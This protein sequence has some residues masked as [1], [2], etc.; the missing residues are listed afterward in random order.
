MDFSIASMVMAFTAGIL[1]VASPCVFPLLP[2]IASGTSNDHKLRPLMITAGLT[3]TFILMG[4]VSSVFGSLIASKMFY[5]EKGAGVI[6]VV[7]GLLMIFDINVF[8]KLTLFNNIKTGRTG[9][10]SGFFLGLTLGLIWIPCV[11][12]VLTSVLALVASEGSIVKGI[13]LLSIYSAGFSIPIL[14]AGYFSQFFRNRLKK[15]GTQSFAIRLIGG[16]VLVIF[17]IYIFTKGL[18]S[19]GL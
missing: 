4:I 15:I 11:G 9:V 10:F 2:I 12:P 13:V 17:G 16:S 1:S 7:F 6:I 19:F 3:L 5:V 18:V 8:K 14:I